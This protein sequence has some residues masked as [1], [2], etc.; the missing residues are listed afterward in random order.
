LYQQYDDDDD[1]DDDESSRYEATTETQGKAQVILRCSLE[2][3]ILMK[4][5]SNMCLLVR[6]QW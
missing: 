1:D 3:W 5:T 6:D 4:W 2:K